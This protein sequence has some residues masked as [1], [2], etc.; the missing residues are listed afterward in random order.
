M[1]IKMSDLV[2]YNDK[3]LRCRKVR[4]FTASRYSSSCCLSDSYGWT[5]GNDNRR[6]VASPVKF[7]IVNDELRRSIAKLTSK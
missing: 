1:M 7:M 4:Q 3:G 5:A 2:P 6:H